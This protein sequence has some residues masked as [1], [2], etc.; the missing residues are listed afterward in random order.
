M[1]VLSTDVLLLRTTIAQA[2]TDK[3]CNEVISILF[4]CSRC[5]IR[6][7][8]P[9]QPQQR[10][11]AWSP[12]PIASSSPPR[13]PSIATTASKLAPPQRQDLT[14][15]LLSYLTNQLTTARAQNLHLNTLTIVTNDLSVRQL[16]RLSS[17]ANNTKLGSGVRVFSTAI[18]TWEIRV[19][20]YFK[21][22]LVH[23][24]L[25]RVAVRMRADLSMTLEKVS[26]QII[27][28][29]RKAS[30]GSEASAKGLTD[31]YLLRAYFG[32]QLWLHD[33]TPESAEKR[34]RKQWYELAAISFVEPYIDACPRAKAAAQLG[35][36]VGK[37]MGIGM[38]DEEVELALVNEVLV[39]VVSPFAGAVG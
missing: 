20:L 17:T 3:L 7:N 6:Q 31:L 22:H 34:K 32:T 30:S 15:S 33:Q 19:G 1:V 10:R 23:S 4:Q 9:Q 13:K 16:R 11:T 27:A 24:Q 29:G 18:G 38:G 14:T 26:K 5:L 12:H 35:R 25:R 2:A 36:R 8:Q 37:E 28:Q 21:I 39:Q